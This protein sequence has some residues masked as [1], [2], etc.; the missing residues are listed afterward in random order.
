MKLCIQIHVFHLSIF[1]D[2]IISKQVIMIATCHAV[3]LCPNH[4]QRKSMWK[5]QKIGQK[6]EKTMDLGYLAWEIHLL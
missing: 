2:V 1:Q 6:G 5:G 4:T 3:N